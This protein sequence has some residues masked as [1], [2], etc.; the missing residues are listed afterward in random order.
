L[1][2]VRAAATEEAKVGTEELEQQVKELTDANNALAEEMINQ[3]VPAMDTTLTKAQ[4][5]T[6]EWVRQYD[7]IMALI[8]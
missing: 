4:E 1:N 5:L 6:A 3:V 7:A 2:E 8:D